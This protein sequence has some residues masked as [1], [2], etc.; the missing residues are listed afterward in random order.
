MSGSKRL[1]FVDDEDSIRTMLPLISQG[2]GFHVTSAANVREALDKIKS[3]SFDVL[4][5]DPN[6]DEPQDGYAV[7]RAMRQANPVASRLF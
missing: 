4:L 3:Y 6:I 1:L 2:Y 5:S 7:V